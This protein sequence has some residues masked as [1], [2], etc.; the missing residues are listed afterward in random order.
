MLAWGCIC[1]FIHGMS[2]WGADITACFLT[3]RSG[4]PIPAAYRHICTM[5]A[6]LLSMLAHE[7]TL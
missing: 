1:G 4:N 5:H 3:H 7:L 2:G 6:I